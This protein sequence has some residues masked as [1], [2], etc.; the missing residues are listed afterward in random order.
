MNELKQML[1]ICN[2]NDALRYNRLRWFGHLER[3]QADR[4]PKKI[5]NYEIPGP[6]CRGGQKKKWIHNVNKD[7]RHLRL[8]TEVAQDRNAWRKA[9]KKNQLNMVQPPNLGN[10]GL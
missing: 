8:R 7:L 9:I 2:I 6:N 10:N 1:G 4:W 3:M 5:L